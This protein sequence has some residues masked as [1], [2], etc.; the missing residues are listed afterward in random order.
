[1]QRNDASLEFL[2]RPFPVWIPLLVGI[3]PTMLLAYFADKGKFGVDLAPYFGWKV[4]WIY[5]ATI[6]VV[7]C[8][9]GNYVQLARHEAQIPTADLSNSVP[10]FRASVMSGTNVLN[11]TFRHNLADLHNSI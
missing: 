2:P 9:I 7:V 6:F 1:M 5:A 4:F 11:N 10:W 8:S 3:I